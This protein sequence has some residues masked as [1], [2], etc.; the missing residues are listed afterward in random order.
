MSNKDVPASCHYSTYPIDSALAEAMLLGIYDCMSSTIYMPTEL[1]CCK[2]LVCSNNVAYSGPY[3]K[4]GK[5]N[6]SAHQSS[7]AIYIDKHLHT[8]LIAAT[9][10]V[11]CHVMLQTGPRAE[12]QR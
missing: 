10:V 12:T 2:G 9:S 4:V 3:G 11:K 7:L 6:V 1:Y 5:L 8:T